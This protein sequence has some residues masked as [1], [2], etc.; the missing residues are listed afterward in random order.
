MFG[1]TSSV[2]PPRIAS[3]ST[4]PP[5]AL[6]ASAAGVRQA[7]RAPRSPLAW[8]LVLPAVAVAINTVNLLPTLAV[9]ASFAL[10]VGLL[11]RP[12]LP[13]VLLFICLMQWLQGAL[14][15]LYADLLGVEVWTLTY[16]RNI[17]EATYLTLGWVSAIAIGAW[18]VTR[19]LALDEVATKESIALSFPHLLIAYGVWTL[20]LPIIAAVTPPQALQVLGAI[21]TLR[22]ALVFAIFVYGGS[23][24]SGR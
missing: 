17:E 22:W 7:S 23:M 5:A 3:L 20:A 9:I 11:W 13:P 4:R 15:V 10:I 16:A 21:A 19:R 2:T 24:N 12:G 8:L 1:S 6:G 14:L 18:L